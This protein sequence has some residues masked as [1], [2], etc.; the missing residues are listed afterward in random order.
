MYSLATLITF[1]AFSA[2]LALAI[3]AGLY[4]IIPAAY[5]RSE[6]QTRRYGRN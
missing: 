3:L 6:H 4:L 5:R 2:A 1:G